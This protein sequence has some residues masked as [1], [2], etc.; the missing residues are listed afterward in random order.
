MNHEDFSNDSNYIRGSH[1][2]KFGVNIRWIQVNAHEGRRNSGEIRFDDLEDFL[3]NLG[4][5]FRALVPG[6]DR[7][8]SW[9]HEY[10][11]VYLQDNIKLNPRLTLNAGLRYEF[12]TMPDEKYGRCFNLDDL[13][14]FPPREGC[15]LITDNPTTKNFAP[16]LGLAWDLSGDGKTALRAGFGI[17]HGNLF[18]KEYQTPGQSQAPLATVISIRPGRGGV[19]KDWRA[20]VSGLS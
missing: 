17:F 20:R 11:G 3:D 19:P 6:G 7:F 15:P 2:F 10:Y 5:R 13:L 1:N 18:P 8:R 9:R 12:M 16:R 14:D 4:D